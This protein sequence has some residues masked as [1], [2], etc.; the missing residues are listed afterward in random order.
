M[1]R[2][3][4]R[5][6]FAVAACTGLA[7]AVAAAAAAAAAAAEA[8]RPA[9][10]SE[11]FHGPGGMTGLL[12]PPAVGAP[13]SAAVLIVH[14]ALGLDRRSHR[15]VAQLTAAG[16]LVLEVELRA[17]PPDGVAEPLPTYAE[18]D[19]LVAGAAAA[20]ARDPRVDP[21]RIGALGFGVGARAVALAPP[22][23]DG[24]ATFAARLLLYPGCAGLGDLLRAS[25][26][27][28]APVAAPVLVLHGE[29][30]PANTAAECDGLAAVLGPPTAPARR[31]SYRGATYAWDL[32]QLAASGYAQPWPG[33]PGVMTPARPWMEL[34][35]LTAA[36]A[37]AFLV[38]ALR[39]TAVHPD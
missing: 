7:V 10:P 18:A 13:P 33:R 25:A 11:G 14:D 22:A 19:A 6:R 36:K 15:Y 29:D 20:L 31:I 30:D 28:R 5:L 3:A 9:G 32:P 12:Y 4:P 24:R 8:R 39:A 38:G 1:M 16:L 2:R 21:T 37:A 17:N 27:A 34:A 23:E 26:Q 35:D